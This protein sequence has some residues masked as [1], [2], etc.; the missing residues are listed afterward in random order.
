MELQQIEKQR[1]TRLEYICR[2]LE[3]ELPL[4][5]EGT[6]YIFNE[7]YYAEAKEMPKTSEIGIVLRGQ[8]ATNARIYRRVNRFIHTEILH[9]LPK[10]EAER[11]ILKR[12]IKGSYIDRKSLV[13]DGF[14]PEKNRVVQEIKRQGIELKRMEELLFKTTELLKHYEMLAL[15]SKVGQMDHYI[16]RPMTFYGALA[17]FALET[18]RGELK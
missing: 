17:N 3:K 5:S 18:V 1:L 13:G 4:Y 9:E 15:N 16:R 14:N 10:D 2:K 8:I 12:I 11:E 7:E 6:S